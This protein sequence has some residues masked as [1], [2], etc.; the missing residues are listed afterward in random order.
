MDFLL[1]IIAAAGRRLIDFWSGIHEFL[2]FV[3]SIFGSLRSIRHMRFR[4]I[5]DIAINQMRFTGIDSLPFIVIVAMILGGT[6]I[7]QALTSLPKFGIEGFLGNL[8]VI[9]VAREMGPLITALI[10]VARSGSAIASETAIQ[11]QNGEIRAFVIMGIDIRL[12]IIVPRI[13]ACVLSLLSLIII[14]DLVAFAGGYL[15]SMSAAYIPVGSFFEALLD[16]LTVKD[17]VA[18]L[19]KSF[20]YGIFVPTL[21]CYYGLKPRFSFEVPIFVSKAVTR[22][23]VSLIIINAAISV[24]FYL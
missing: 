16:A 8:M 14:F 15:I 19:L 2:I 9:I 7:I 13:I 11:K 6:V 17:L 21:C 3:V 24:L 23:L 22:T 1:N 5:Y 18:M 4:S 12:Y 10:I 20:L